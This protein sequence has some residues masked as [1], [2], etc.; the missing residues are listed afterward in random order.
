MTRRSTANRAKKGDGG[1]AKN[2]PSNAQSVLVKGKARI[3]ANGQTTPSTEELRHLIAEAAY[4]RGAR[5]G[6][7]PR[8]EIDDW[9]DNIRAQG[10]GN[11]P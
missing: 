4:L 3:P 1:R 7:A 6:F 5:R 10:R 9:L 11:L 2:Q 8:G